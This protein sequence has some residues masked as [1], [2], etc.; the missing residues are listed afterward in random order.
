MHFILTASYQWKKSGERKV[1]NSELAIKTISNSVATY[2]TKKK[3]ADGT[4]YKIAYKRLRAS[5]GGDI[6]DKII[7]RIRTSNSIIVD[8][9]HPNPNVYLELG[10]TIALSIKNGGS[11][12]VYLIREKNS[13]DFIEPP[14]DLKGFF[15][16]EYILEKG[17]IV[18][19]DQGSLRMSLIGDVK[20][21][22][23]GHEKPNDIINDFISP[24]K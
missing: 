21:F 5:A 17:K 19:K 6:L 22:F 2:F 10:I 20:E 1:P 8:I 3:L 4:E 11:L 12:N 16:S 14:S 15:I 23:M 18:F 9:S 13:K 7:Q 24:E